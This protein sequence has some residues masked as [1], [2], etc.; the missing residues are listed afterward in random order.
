[1]D[2][3]TEARAIVERA[4]GTRRP[5]PRWVWIAACVVTAICVGAFAIGMLVGGTSGKPF[6]HGPPQEGGVGGYWIGMMIGVGVGV[7][8]GYA[9]AMSR[10]DRE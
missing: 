1:V 6:P 2:R 7:P 5:T 8:I 10:R 9:I 4:R 3:E